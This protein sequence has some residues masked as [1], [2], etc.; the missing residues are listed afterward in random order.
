MLGIGLMY[1]FALVLR[2]FDPKYIPLQ[3]EQGL[4]L[5]AHPT[6]EP[7]MM[8]PM[9]MARKVTTG[10]KALRSTCRRRAEPRLRPHPP[11]LP[12]TGAHRRPQAGRVGG[13]GGG[14]SKAF[15]M[16]TS[17]L[18]KKKGG[19]AAWTPPPIPFQ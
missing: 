12:A 14:F 6:M 5:A 2:W 10:I 18:S 4:H 17:P 7:A 13:P 1:L 15:P 16:G 9:A 3:D 19:D 11:Y 8:S